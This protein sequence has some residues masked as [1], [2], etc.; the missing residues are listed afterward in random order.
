MSEKIAGKYDIHL[1]F[2]EAEVSERHKKSTTGLPPL[3]LL[4]HE[5]DISEDDLPAVHDLVVIS[6]DTTA[7]SLYNG[8]R[9]L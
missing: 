8:I 6:I 3:V 1:L 2:G 7:Y 5:I 4:Y 9:N